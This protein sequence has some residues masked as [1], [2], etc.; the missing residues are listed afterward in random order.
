MAQQLR[1]IAGCEGRPMTTKPL[2]NAEVRILRFYRAFRE[3]RFC[4]SIK[5]IA[6]GCAVGT[7]T[8]QRAN[9]RF[10][11]LGILSWVSGNSASWRP[12]SRGQANKYRLVLTGLEGCNVSP[13]TVR[14]LRRALRSEQ[15]RPHSQPN[16]HT[17]PNSPNDPNGHNR[18]S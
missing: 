1:S 5:T 6:Q 8:V 3:E 7:R 14:T 18:H 9:V 10:Q 15:K 16:Q 2:T 13:S 11:Q 4:C 12:D 17:K